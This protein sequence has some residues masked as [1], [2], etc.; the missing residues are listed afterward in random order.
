[1]DEELEDQGGTG[2]IQDDGSHGSDFLDDDPT[3]DP[4]YIVPDD[5]D[6]LLFG[7]DGSGIPLPIINDEFANNIGFKDFER[8]SGIRYV[9]SGGTPEEIAERQ[10]LLNLA[11]QAEINEFIDGGNT[12]NLALIFLAVGAVAIGG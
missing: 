2:G 12:K 1:M 3:V 11:E 8:T 7:Q 6:G 5:D 9:A 10:R 4:G